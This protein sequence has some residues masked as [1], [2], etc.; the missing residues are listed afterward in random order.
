MPQSDFNAVTVTL[1]P[2]AAARPT[3]NVSMLLHNL[4]DAQDALMGPSRTKLIA[5]ATWQADLASLGI[6]DGEAAYESVQSHFSR[7]KKPVKAYLG[8]RGK[9]T[10]QVQTVVVPSVP[11]DGSYIISVSQAGVPAVGSPYFFAAVGSTQSSVRTGLVTNA[12]AGSAMFAVANGVGAGDITITSVVPGIP[13]DIA[14]SSPGSSMTKSVTV[15]T[16]VLAVTQVWTLDIG[17]AAVGNY[18]LTVKTTTGQKTYTHIATTG[19]TAT[20]I[21]D[22]LAS[23]YAG[24]PSDL[25]DATMT[26]VLT[27]KATLAASLAGRPGSITITS[28]A[29]DATVVVTTANYGIVEDLTAIASEN[30]DWYCGLIGSRVAADLLLAREWVDGDGAHIIGVQ[31]SDASILT[32][33]TTDVFSLL[34]ASGSIRC[35]GV[36]HHIDTEGIIEAWA[37]DVLSKP[38]GSVAWV[39]KPLTGFTGRVLT[40]SE[41]QNLRSKE[42]SFLELFSARSESIMNGGYSFG[43]RPIDITRA[44]DTMRSNQEIALMDLS[45]KSDIIPYSELGQARCLGVINTEVLR[46]IEAGYAIAGTFETTFGSIDEALENDRIRGIFPPFTTTG[47]IQAGGH[48]VILN[49]E[50]EQ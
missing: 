28:P 33:S 13:L 40:A 7:P 26:P 50:L 15:G 38:V 46:G 16:S 4:T 30:Q 49:M 37:A 20:T 24:N 19:A 22:G 21:R 41:A 31:S 18:V 3:A 42:G 45:V 29:S 34:K 14:I 5:P 25:F 36:Q 48:K 47:R 17:T 27:D 32:D 43:G 9:D 2:G 6:S 11:S 10:Q 12:G 23:L 1:S 44:I 35:F 39:A 8:R